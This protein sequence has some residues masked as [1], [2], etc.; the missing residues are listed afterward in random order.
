MEALVYLGP[1][2]F[3]LLAAGSY[4]FEREGLATTVRAAARS[5]GLGAY[6]GGAR[7]AVQGAGA[8]PQPAPVHVTTKLEM[9][10]L[11]PAPPTPPAHTGAQGWALVQARPGEFVWAAAI[12]FL[13]NLFCYLAIKH[14]SAT[15]FKVA[16]V[17]VDGCGWLDMAGILPTASA[18]LQCILRLAAGHRTRLPA[19]LAAS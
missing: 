10:P 4:A 3:V 17:W 7:V 16:G 15:S 14:V 11:L 9:A 2:T 5:M 6:G 12:S 13:V 8:L 1:F 19:S 18:M